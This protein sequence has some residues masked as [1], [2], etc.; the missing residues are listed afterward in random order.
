MVCSR[1]FIKDIAMKRKSRILEFKDRSQKWGKI[2]LEWI[3]NVL[4]FLFVL[5]V[6]FAVFRA[7]TAQNIK[8]FGDIIRVCCS[9]KLEEIYN[10]IGATA[11]VLF[12]IVG[13]YEFAY[14][15]GIPFL[16][17]PAFIKVKETNYLK[18]SE[19]MMRLYYEKD[20]DFI[21]QY[22]KE[23]TE[24]LL[25]AMGLEE[26]QFRYINYEI[27]KARVKPRRSIYALKCHAKKIIFHNEFVV[28]QTGLDYSS[29]VYNKVNYFLN[30][31]AAV[32]DEKLCKSLAE[33]MSQYLLLSLQEKIAEIDYI[34][35]PQGGNFL[36]GLEVGK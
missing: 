34:I 31:Y 17:P 8:S 5:A 14:L 2:I 12:G 9:L 3:G 20:I 11:F 15:N 19:K 30:L 36:L 21:E 23:R 13:I 4:H 18:Q 6:L 33:I 7:V 35:I 29:I 10:F 27:I 25:Q 32:Y 24:H 28:D 16:A 26:K 22:E 1:K